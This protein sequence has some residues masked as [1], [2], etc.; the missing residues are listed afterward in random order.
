MTRRIADD[1]APMAIVECRFAGFSIVPVN[2]DGMLISLCRADL[3]QASNDR[4]D[5][6]E[7]FAL[8]YQMKNLHVAS[9]VSGSASLRRRSRNM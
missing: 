9:A 2:P 3:V 6:P 5:A 8:A 1:E 4:E 7:I